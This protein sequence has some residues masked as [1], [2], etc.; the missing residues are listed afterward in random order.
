MPTIT[1]AIATG[2]N[3]AIGAEFFAS[4]IYRDGSAVVAH[5]V[6]RAGPGAQVMGTG[7]AL[8]LHATALGKVLVAFD[9]AAAR[10]VIG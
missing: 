5:H 3:Q 4:V 2:E 9:P 8:P 1:N 6:F 7:K 10:S